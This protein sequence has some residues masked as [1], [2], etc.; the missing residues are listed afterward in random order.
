MA[1]KPTNSSDLASE[2]FTCGPLKEYVDLSKDFADKVSEY[3][4]EPMLMLF[5]S[6]AGL[7]VVVSAIKLL[8]NMTNKWEMAKDGVFISITGILLGSQATGLISYVYSGALSIM[9]SS[10]A[11]IFSIAGDVKGSTGYSGLVALAANGEKAMLSVFQSAGA[12]IDA[13]NFYSPQLYLYAAVLVFPYLL[14]IIAYSTQVVV[15]IFRLMMVAI[16]APFLFMAFAFNW[17]RPMAQSGAKTLLASILVLFASTAALALAVYGVNA[18]PIDDPKE[19]TGAKV[20]EFASIGNP[21]FLIIMVLG[22]IGTALMTEG[23]SLANSIAGTALTNTAAGTMTAGTAGSA[24]FLAG[25][26]KKGLG[27]LPGPVGQAAKGLGTIYDRGKALLD[28]KKNINKPGGDG[29][30]FDTP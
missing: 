28:R 9:S 11:M 23:V 5:A 3:L 10:S 19:L 7:W 15:G 26:G 1:R 22:W 29:H 30:P 8:L 24:L 16:F 12:I 25:M 13:A 4:Q 14:L 18:I 20:R 27:M 21:Q 2:C 17:G 6:L